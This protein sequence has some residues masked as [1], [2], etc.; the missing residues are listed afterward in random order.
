VR[1]ATKAQRR[2][3]KYAVRIG[4]SELTEI[5][6]SGEYTSGGDADAVANYIANITVWI[7]E[8]LATFTGKTFDKVGADLYDT[9]DE[10]GILTF[11]AQR[12]QLNFPEGDGVL[13][14][15]AIRGAQVSFSRSINMVH[16][17]RGA[18]QPLSG[19]GHL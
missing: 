8:V 1:D 5:T 11:Q 19:V 17:L 16:G 14:D 13:D 7:D 10:R 12:K 15:P 2:R 9:D 3:A 18:T 6:F 4:E